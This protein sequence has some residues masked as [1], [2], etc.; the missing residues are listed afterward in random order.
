MDK[1]FCN[2]ILIILALTTLLLSSCEDVV[3]VDLDN[4]DI[5][6]V[7]VEAYINTKPENNI[8]VKLKRTLPV[9]E[10]EENPPINNA[11]VRISDDQDI[12]NTV[13]LEEYVNTGM[14]I[15]PQNIYYTAQPGR[16][17]YLHITL[18]DGVE[19]NGSDFLQE[20]EPLDSV[21][22]NLSARG[23]YEFLAIFIDAPNY[24]SDTRYYK[25]DI[26][27]NGNMLYESQ[28]MV[29]ASD[30][31]VDG[32]YIRNFEIFTDYALNDD[33]K[34]L[35]K[36]DTVS[37]EQ[38]SI[39]ET[40]YDFYMGMINQAFT[41]GPYSVPPA[42]LTG[43]LT[44]SDGKKVLGIF[45]ARDVALGNKVAIDDSNFQPLAS[46]VPGSN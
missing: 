15:L 22:V 28:N 43:N 45:S 27:I 40:A 4:T 2:K 29:I 25:W 26:F 10:S 1:I 24:P 6:L 31:L 20:V 32:N 33:D 11:V 18:P 44:S 36:G 17:Y 16:T 46:L 34:I 3:Q 14:Y 42:N 38:L 7:S 12:V 35:L 8:Y 37:V 21:K 30:E 39:S 19:I 5:D 9:D 13:I 23:D 41:G